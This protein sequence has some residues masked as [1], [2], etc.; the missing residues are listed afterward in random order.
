MP[1]LTA[2][3]D[4]Q[5][6]S[7]TVVLASGDPMLYGIGSTLVRLLGADHVTVLPHPSSVSLAAARLGWSLDDLEVITTVGRPLALV[8]PALQPA[9]AYS[10][11]SPSPPRPPTSANSSVIA[12]SGPAG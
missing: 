3:L 11:W 2:L 5:D 7:G 6:A 9:G 12:G 8:H 10:S 4:Q 1:A